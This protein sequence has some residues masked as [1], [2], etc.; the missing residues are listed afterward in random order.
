MTR[1]G[2]FTIEV[3]LPERQI[4]KKTFEIASK[5]SRDYKNKDLVIIAVL[6]GSFIFCADLI[7]NLD[8][9][10]VIDF[11]RI[12]SYVGTQSAVKVKVISD[13]KEDLSGKDVLI[14]EDIVDTGA[15]LDFLI[16]EISL[17]NPKSIETCAFLDKRCTRQKE[18]SLAY[19]CFEM[20]DDFVVGYGLDYNGFFR[21]LPYV[22]RIK[23]FHK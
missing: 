19:S 20:K 16:N 15:T 23:E 13:F 18:V 7:R 3:I 4:R 21:G 11:I 22:G 14:V 1:E 12:S 5:I 9:R 8:V 2:N 10:C 17:K 6:K